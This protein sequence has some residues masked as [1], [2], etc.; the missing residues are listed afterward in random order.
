MITCSHGQSIPISNGYITLYLDDGELNRNSAI[1]LRADDYTFLNMN[2]CKL[3][4]RLPIRQ[5]HGQ[6]DA[7]ACQFSGATWHPTCYDYPEETYRK[8]SKK[9][10]LSKFEA[11][12]KAIEAVKPKLYL[13]FSRP[14]MFS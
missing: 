7:F 6:I 4:D 10:M 1:L 3:H 12:A 14:G 8:I 9:K 13:P 2:D 11:M 5:T